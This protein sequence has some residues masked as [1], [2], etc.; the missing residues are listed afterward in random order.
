M[1]TSI[2]D[3][4]CVRMAGSDLLFLLPPTNLPK[5]KPITW[6]YNAKDQNLYLFQDGRCFAKTLIDMEDKEEAES[7]FAKSKSVRVVEVS[8]NGDLDEF[9]DVSMAPQITN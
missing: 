4:I 3:D 1:S 9:I 8:E 6:H 5:N 2:I 7:I